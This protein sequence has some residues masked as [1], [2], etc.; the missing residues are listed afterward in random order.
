MII[1]VRVE[2]DDTNTYMCHVWVELLWTTNPQPLTRKMDMTWLPPLRTIFLNYIY[3]HWLWS[4]NKDIHI[5]LITK[6]KHNISLGWCF[7]S[8]KVNFLL[9]YMCT[10]KTF[11][12]RLFVKKKSIFLTSFSKRKKVDYGFRRHLLSSNHK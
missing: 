6:H 7:F 9:L 4:R 3:H 2:Q 12:E 8:Q 5:L 11:V 1:R 10:R